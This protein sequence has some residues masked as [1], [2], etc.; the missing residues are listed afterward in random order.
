MKAPVSSSGMENWHLV[1]A[2]EEKSKLVDLEMFSDHCVMFLKNAGHLY[3][4]V[5]SFVSHSV[6]SIKVCFNLA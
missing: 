4:K 1:Y 5:I 6:Q 3:L 2:L